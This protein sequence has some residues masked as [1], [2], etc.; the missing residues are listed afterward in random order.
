MRNVSHHEAALLHLRRHLPTYH[1]TCR[2]LHPNIAAS[3]QLRVQRAHR[4]FTPRRL[5]PRRRSGV[6]EARVRKRDLGRIVH[7]Y[8][9]LSIDKHTPPHQADNGYVPAC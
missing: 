3:E 4:Q 7:P 1:A 5:P 9:P 6:Y 8:A 2:T